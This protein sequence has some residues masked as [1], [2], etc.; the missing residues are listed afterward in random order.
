MW[1]GDPGQTQRRH[2]GAGEALTMRSELVVPSEPEHGPASAFSTSWRLH[3]SGQLE[4]TSDSDCGSGVSSSDEDDPG[5]GEVWAGG[6]QPS[7]ARDE[8][9]GTALTRLK[10]DAVMDASPTTK[11]KADVEFRRLV[12]SNSRAERFI[13]RRAA[14]SKEQLQ[15]EK[16]EAE[17]RRRRRRRAAPARQAMRRLQSTQQMFPVLCARDEQPERS[18]ADRAAAPAAPQPVLTAHPPTHRK[19]KH[20]R[21]PRARSASA[22]NGAISSLPV[23]H[24]NTPRTGRGV[25]ARMKQAAMRARS[26]HIVRCP[27]RSTHIAALPMK[28]CRPLPLRTTSDPEQAG[29]SPAGGHRMPE[30][31]L[32]RMAQ[33]R[34][35]ME[36]LP[37]V[38]IAVEG[39]MLDVCCGSR[40]Y[41]A[42]GGELQKPTLHVRPGLVD[43]LRSISAS[44]QVALATQLGRKP[45]LQLLKH[46]DSNSVTLDAIY[47]L[48]GGDGIGGEPS[49][50][51]H[52]AT[53]AAASTTQDY[54]VVY[55]D[56]GISPHEVGQRVLV[57][58][59]LNLDLDEVRERDGS[60]LLFT[61]S[62]SAPNFAVRLPN[63]VDLSQQFDEAS[64]EHTNG[65]TPSPRHTGS[66]VQATS[67]LGSFDCEGGSIVPVVLLVPNPMS[68]TEFRALPMTAVASAVH[69]L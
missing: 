69:A 44:F 8:S 18:S 60:R 28:D 38:I 37:L 65:V 39:T 63:P 42:D 10:N 12:K 36:G 58:S 52:R 1:P 50:W 40:G 25:S 6:A 11:C 62:V 13:R 66:E 15:R 27:A 59:A 21:T 43:G 32:S 7:R 67:L 24:L 23:P 16:E 19:V 14:P 17:Q 47:L 33:R 35:H 56:F 29:E 54:A 48:P 30:E 46:L 61:P 49:G 57:V 22:P 31:L 20:P 45:L 2:S 34:P 41:F 4:A 51:G 64:T 68:H 55:S 9:F 3:K 26:A 5:A 53:T